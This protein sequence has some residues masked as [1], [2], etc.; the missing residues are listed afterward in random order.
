MFERLQKTIAQAG[1]ASRRKAEEMILQ[2]RVTV[3]GKLVTELGTKVDI[4]RDHVKVDGRI[5]R[6]QPHVY[7][8]LNKPQGV[9]STTSDTSNRTKVTDLVKT[10]RRIYPAGRLDFDSDGLVILTNDGRLAKAI[11]ESG[12]VPKH[13]RVKVTGRPSQ[14]KVERLRWGLRLKDGTRLMPCQIKVLK[15]REH[16]WYEVVLRQ[17][18][19]R[20]IRRMFEEIGHRVMRLRRVRIGP[21][22]LEGLRPGMSRKLSRREVRKLL[23]S[24]QEKEKK[25][26]G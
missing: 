17:G 26:R 6:P 7:Y 4:S 16:T 2:G 1:I 13:Y 23:D 10:S 18:R 12:Q 14:E 25:T 11:T 21:V 15:R 9:L 24:V 20:Q 5:L 19:N 22:A 3:N 8:A